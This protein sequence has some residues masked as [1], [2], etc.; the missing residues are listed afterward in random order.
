MQRTIYLV[1]TKGIKNNK[2]N[3]STKATF[4]TLREAVKNYNFYKSGCCKRILRKKIV[5]TED[6]IRQKNF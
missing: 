4:R 1:Q 6:I 3:W 2:F 5:E